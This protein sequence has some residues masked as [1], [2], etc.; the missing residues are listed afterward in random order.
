MIRHNLQVFCDEENALEYEYGVLPD[1]L[2]SGGSESTGYET[3]PEVPAKP[4]TF[5]STPVSTVIDG[6]SDAPDKKMLDIRVSVS[7]RNSIQST[8]PPPSYAPPPPSKTVSL[9]RFKTR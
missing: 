7:R 3:P 6:G 9:K 1:S 4:K 8:T 2:A 5:T